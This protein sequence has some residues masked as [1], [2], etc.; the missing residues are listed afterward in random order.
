MRSRTAPS[1]E[2]VCKNEADKGSLA[3]GDTL[4]TSTLRHPT[5]HTLQTAAATPP[6]KREALRH[7][8]KSSI[9]F[10]GC[11]RAPSSFRSDRWPNDAS[12]IH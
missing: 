6:D 10:G 2:F 1:S 4:G 5:H 3:A 7:S 8:A 12:T 11:P 9:D